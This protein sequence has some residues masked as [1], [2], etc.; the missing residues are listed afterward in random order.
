[1][2]VLVDHVLEQCEHQRW[3]TPLSTIFIV[4]RSVHEVRSL[5]NLPLDVL[6]VEAEAIEFGDDIVFNKG[7]S[8][9]DSMFYEELENCIGPTGS[10]N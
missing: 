10:H 7:V 3:G 6:L 1:M 2:D 8:T 9:L 4:C 5:F